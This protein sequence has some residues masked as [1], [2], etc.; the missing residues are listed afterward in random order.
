MIRILILFVVALICVQTPLRAEEQRSGQ[1]VA[2]A[3][4]D[5]FQS[6]RKRSNPGQ[7]TLRKG[8]SYEVLAIN[9]AGGEWFRVQVPHAPT[10]TARWVH[11]DCGTFAASGQSSVKGTGARDQQTTGSAGSKEATDLVLALSWQP[12]F[13]ERFRSKPECVDLN[14]GRLPEAARQ[15]SLHGLWPKDFYCDVPKDVRTLDKNRDWAALPAPQLDTDT[16]QRLAIAMPGM[17]SDLHRHEWIKH[18]TCFFGDRGGDEYYDDSLLL[19]DAINTS[20]VGVLF[21]SHIGKN[22]SDAQIRAA[23]DEAFGPGA[24][25]RV[26]VDCADDDGDRLIAELKISLKG[27]ITDTVD[28]GALIRAAPPRRRDCR[29]GIVDPH[30]AQ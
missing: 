1:F 6:K 23:F 29:S 5:A 25:D 16:A 15:L 7:V 10:P 22:L 20:S 4:C 2:N 24:G 17:Q 13:C 9:A 14:N 19:L 27:E 8:Q 18:G 26:E 11:R 30:G 3:T 21:A 28:V 12:T